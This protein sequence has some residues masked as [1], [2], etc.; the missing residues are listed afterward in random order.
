MATKKAPLA[1]KAKSETTSMTI[2]E[3]RAV[4]QD[5][6]KLQLKFLLKSA[7]AAG[8]NLEDVYDKPPVNITVVYDSVNQAAKV[9]QAGDKVPLDA[10]GQPVVNAPAQLKPGQQIPGTQNWRPW[11]RN[12]LDQTQ[13][14]S[15]VPMPIPGLV[16]PYRDEEGREKIK[17]DVNDLV[18]WLTCGVENTVNKFFWN[19]YQNAYEQWKELEYFKR[20]GPNHAPWAQ[21]GLHGEPAWSFT[22]FAPSFGMNSDGRSLRIGPPTVL[23]VVEGETAQLPPG[24]NTSTEGEQ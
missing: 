23:D 8:I 10:L 13:M 5:Q 22:P 15:F 1:S 17:L 2:E 7:A 19:V 20:H 16:Y 14:I 24:S 9:Q 6:F 21:V 12:D 4:M 18:C 11:N 3:E